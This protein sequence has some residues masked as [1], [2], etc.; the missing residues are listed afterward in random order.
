[1]DDAA[2]AALLERLAKVGK[3]IEQLPPEVRASA[4]EIMRP[5]IA[6]IVA[7]ARPAGRTAIRSSE[8]QSVL[9]TS[10]AEAFFGAFEHAKPSD[11]ARLIAAY[12]YGEYGNEPF[13][14]VKV[15][16]ISEN[17]GLTVPERLDMTFLDAAKDGKKLFQRGGRGN[18][19]PTVHGEAVLKRDF[20]VTKGKKRPEGS[21]E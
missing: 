1:M 5:Y 3:A 7:P 13:S 10:D 20:R 12:W 16:E 8:E 19:R 15:K 11:N 21:T 2:F 9:D 17:A 18:F 6:G 14:L 4:F